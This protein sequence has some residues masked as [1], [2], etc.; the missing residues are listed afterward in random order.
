MSVINQVLDQLERR[1][2]HAALKQNMVR[3]VPQ[4]RRNTLSWVL[5]ASG[6]LWL[7]G[8][9]LWL[10]WT[11]GGANGGARA[12]RPPS[13][14]MPIVF[15]PVSSVAVLTEVNSQPTVAPTQERVQPASRLS[16]ELSALPVQE[17]KRK[18]NPA[19]SAAPVEATEKRSGKSQDAVAPP[20]YGADA[21]LSLKQVSRAQQADAEFRR[22]VAS[23]QQGRGAEAVASYEAALR[24]DA[25]HDAARQALVALLLEQHR[26]AD[27]ERVL[28]ERLGSKPEHTGFAMLLARLQVER[29]AE[30]EALA[31]LERSLRFA[32]RNAE[33]HAFVAALLQRNNRHAEAVAHYQTALQLQPNHGAWLMGYGLSLQALGRNDAAKAAFLHALESKTL[34]P[35][36]QAFVRQ[37]LKGL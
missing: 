18:P 2:A 16:L 34:S 32:E 33:Y 28:Q 30:D 23:M 4:A 17:P 22:G 11:Q 27:A 19:A 7:L 35:E 25:T 14:A 29:A 8:L 15:A 37:R 13:V 5:M 6:V 20:V 9:G 31:T 12:H 36:L 26:R 1:G 3:V 21:N 10:G 24:L